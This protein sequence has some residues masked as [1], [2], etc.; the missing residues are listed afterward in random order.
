MK[1][2]IN[3][4]S[5]CLLLSLLSSC[6][7]DSDT[8]ANKSVHKLSLIKQDGA[9]FIRFYYENEKLV[10]IQQDYTIYDSQNDTNQTQTAH[11]FFEYE[12]DKL[13]RVSGD[14]G[15][16]NFNYEGADLIISNFHNQFPGATMTFKNYEDNDKFRVEIFY[17]EGVE[18]KF[19]PVFDE[20]DN[21]IYAND[22][23]GESVE[24]SYPGFFYLSQYYGNY[25][26]NDLKH[27]G[28][29]FDLEV[30]LYLYQKPVNR[31][32]DYIQRNSK[33]I[34]Y[35]YEFDTNNFPITSEAMTI[36]PTSND[37]IF[38]GKKDYFYE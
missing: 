33:K 13:T 1:F 14:L 15:D 4:I 34:E 17:E 22:D 5:L 12:N 16:T 2:S 11:S 28:S 30:Q 19:N 7:K 8:A 29:N 25:T 18:N 37:T 6:G 26:Y 35:K 24:D 23:A 27:I 32:V 20:N 3:V 9:D 38:H 10:E 36:Y 31:S 21:V